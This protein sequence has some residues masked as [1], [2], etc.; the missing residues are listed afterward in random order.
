MGRS[1]TSTWVGGTVVVALLLLVAGWFLLISPVMA[2]ASET[3]ATAEGVE[4]DN[5]MARGRIDALKKQFA[6]LDASKADLADLQK[7]VPTTGQL[8][9]Y[10]RQVDE[11]AVAHGVAVT[12][13]TPSTPELFAPAGP[14]T[15][16]TEAPVADGTAGSTVTDGTDAATADGAAVSSTNAAAGSGAP[17]GMVD[18][19][20]T[21]TAV[22]SYANV[23]AWVQSMQEQ[24]D[25]LLLVT[26][27]TGTAQDDAA[28]GGGK[29]ATKV[30][31]V[32]V[33]I[34]GYL[35]VLPGEDSIPTVTPEEQEAQLPSA[36]PNRNP[37]LG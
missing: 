31:D 17:V 8:A 25:R 1:K 9:A 16:A 35:Y 26:S 37:L 20:I 6:E 27:V 29:P 33:T 19:P 32:E 24:T 10:L 11:Q 34:T 30:G 36:D 18:V 21:M 23:V 7:Q 4:A 3:R 13:V 5:D 2:T 14:P 12:G 22:G 15:A 28:P